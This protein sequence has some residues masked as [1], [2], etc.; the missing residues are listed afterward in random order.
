[1][2]SECRDRAT[3]SLHVDLPPLQTPHQPPDCTGAALRA[4][5][6]PGLRPKVSTG[7]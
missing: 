4:W 6:N 7:V 3:E 5:Q 2:N 1:M